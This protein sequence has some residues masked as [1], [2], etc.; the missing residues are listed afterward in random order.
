M[1][2]IVPKFKIEVHGNHK[3]VACLTHDNK[4]SVERGLDELDY[5]SAIEHLIRNSQNGEAVE[6]SDNNAMHKIADSLD[7]WVDVL[8]QNHA[9]TIADGISEISQQL[10]Q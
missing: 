4:I 1:K 2:N 7:V 3:L 5:V 10:R 8:K 6:R 9:F